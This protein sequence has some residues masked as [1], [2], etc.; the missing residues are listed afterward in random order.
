MMPTHR[1]SARRGSLM[2][3]MAALIFVLAMLCGAVMQR[4]LDA[5]RASARLEQRLQTQAAA[6]GAVAVLLAGVP[7]RTMEDLEIGRARVSFE[8]ARADG[9]R[10]TVA[11]RVDIL[12][13][14]GRPF[15]ST[16]YRSGFVQAEAGAW[17]LERLE[18]LP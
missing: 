15:V 11:M 10:L 1:N 14:E 17:N 16:N 7:D 18:P 9:P 6:E 13:R 12:S 2:L 3:G 4:S 8:P 5:Y